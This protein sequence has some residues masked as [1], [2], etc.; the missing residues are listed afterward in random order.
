MNTADKIRSR[1]FL[2][3]CSFFA[4]QQAYARFMYYDQYN[5]VLVST[6]S[7]VLYR[8]SSEAYNKLNKNTDQ[9]T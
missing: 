9:Y 3:F 8:V 7:L 1:T 5:L 6:T 2:W 4:S